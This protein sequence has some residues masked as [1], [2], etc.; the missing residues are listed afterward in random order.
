[1]KIG[2]LLLT[3]PEHEDSGT[4]YRLCEEFLKQGHSIEIFLMEDGVFN[5]ILTQSPIRLIPSWDALTQKGLQI[6]LCTQTTQQRGL[7]PEQLLPGIKLSNQHHLAKMVAS[8]DRFLIF[9]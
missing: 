4:V 6:S 5:G 7:L 1:M 8:S 9:G 2:F 3:S